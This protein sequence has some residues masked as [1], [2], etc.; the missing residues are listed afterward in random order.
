MTSGQD[1][2]MHPEVISGG[3]YRWPFPLLLSPSVSPISISVYVFAHPKNIRALYR[4]EFSVAPAILPINL[5][6]A[7]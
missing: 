3:A 4:P 1:A 7:G 2:S 5:S 6:L